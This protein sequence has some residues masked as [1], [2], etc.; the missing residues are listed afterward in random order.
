M[1]DL[2]GHSGFMV[3]DLTVLNVRRLQKLSSNSPGLKPLVQQE[4]QRRECETLRR[5]NENQLRNIRRTECY[6][7]F[8]TLRARLAGE[9]LRKRETWVDSPLQ[10]EVAVVES[11]GAASLCAVALSLSPSDLRVGAGVGCANLKRL[12]EAVVQ[13]TPLL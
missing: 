3:P 10:D 6:G 13:A 8:E 2:P 1:A 11:L 12:V 4:L 5:L 7:S 9:E